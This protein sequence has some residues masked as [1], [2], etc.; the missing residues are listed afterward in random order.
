[1][2]IFIGQVISTKMSKTATVAVER[3]VVHP[4]YKKRLKRTKKYHVHDELGV[5]VGDKVT[6]A[7]CKPVSKLKKWKII[8]VVGAKKKEIKKPVSKKG[9]KK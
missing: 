1:M 6:F 8:E 9:K 5:K 7:A 3:I 4:I 2:K